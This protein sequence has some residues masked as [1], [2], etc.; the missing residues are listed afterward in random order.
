MIR[1][2][3]TQLASS[4]PVAIKVTGHAAYGDYGQD[5][6]CASVSTLIL[7]FLNSLEA[8]ADYI[9]DYNLNQ[10]DGGH[11][12]IDFSD[13][14]RVSKKEVVQILFDS[15]RLGMTLLARDSAEYISTKVLIKN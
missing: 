5:V 11:L 1:A 6:M 12:E 4:Q 13:F 3:I 9:P 14:E 2:T 15:F 8:L 10:E 7:N